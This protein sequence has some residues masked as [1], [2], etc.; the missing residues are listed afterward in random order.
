MNR[1]AA[2]LTA[3]L[4]LCAIAAQGIPIPGTQGRCLCPENPSSNFINPKTIQSLQYIPKGSHCERQ[5]IIIT[6]ETGKIVCVSPNAKWVKI[7][8]KSRQGSI[9]KN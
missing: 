8:F 1:A 4:L 9:T 3:I 5:E 7:I 2:V 6:M